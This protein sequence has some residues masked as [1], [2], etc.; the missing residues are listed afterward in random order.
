MYVAINRKHK[1]ECKI[2]NPSC[3]RIGIM[4]GL[5]LGKTAVEKLTHLDKNGTGMNLCHTI[6]GSQG[7]ATHIMGAHGI[8]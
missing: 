5:M 8:Y 4:V 1:N 2:Q 7:F 6:K 3:G